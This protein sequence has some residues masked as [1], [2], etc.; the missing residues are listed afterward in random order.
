[1]EKILTKLALA[2][3][4]LC[5]SAVL[6]SAACSTSAVTAPSS[7]VYRTVIFKSNLHCENCVKKVVENISYVKGVKDLVVSLENQ[8]ITITYDAAK[9][10][11]VKL[12]VEIKKLGYAAVE[13]NQ[14]K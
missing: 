4:L 2:L 12:A 1:M 3:T 11:P 9:T 10:D 13:V 14:N 8:T 6:V 5:G 7:K